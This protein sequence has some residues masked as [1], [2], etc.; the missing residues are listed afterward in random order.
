MTTEQSLPDF[1]FNELRSKLS[2]PTLDTIDPGRR[3][4]AEVPLLRLA[5]LDVT[6]LSDEE[7]LHAYQRAEH[8][9]HL[10]ALKKLAPEVI[11]RPTLDKKVNKAEAHGFWPNWNR[12]ARRRSCTSKP[13][14]RLPRQPA[15]RA[16]PGTWPNC[17]CASAG[18]KSNR[19]IDCSTTS[20]RTTCASRSVAQTL[21]HV[22]TDAGIIN[23]DGTLAT[24]RRRSRPAWWSLAPRR[25]SPGKI[26]TPGGETAPAGKKS[27]IWTP[28]TD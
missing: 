19:P 14:A 11:A 20:A 4:P 22:L 18:A 28:G 7:L 24:R 12:T 15:R 6:K 23:P 21:F 8:F 3:R 27:A 13:R 17:R 16:G 25:P 5:R 9:R 2:L 1:D 10:R 26:W